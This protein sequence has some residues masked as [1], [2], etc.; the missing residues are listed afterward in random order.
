[1]ARPLRIHLPGARYHVMSRGNGGQRIF[2]D[3]RDYAKFLALLA[4]SLARFSVRCLS[5]CLM[6]THFHLVLEPGER[7]ISGMMQQLNSSYARWFNKRRQ[8]VGHVFQGRFKALVVDTDHYFLRLLRYVAR[9]PVESGAVSRP[10]AWRWSSYRGTAGAEPPPEFLAID[11]VL[12][13]LHPTDATAARQQFI[14]LVASTAEDLELP[15]GL[16]FGSA[17]FEQRV[18]PLLRARRTDQELSY[19]ERY[20]IRPPLAA[21]LEALPDRDAVN[22]RMHEAFFEHA[23][24]LREIG[25]FVGQHPSTIWRRIR[26]RQTDSVD[27]SPPGRR[28]IKNQDLTPRA[29]AHAGPARIKNQDLTPG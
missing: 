26:Q 28:K 3:R 23:Y 5:Y 8:R 4:S 22:R 14:A 10:D 27:P 20:A 24:T 29:T 17:A 12:R 25:D 15:T 18:E 7:P 16:V 13:A 1:M 11:D 19:S 9:N 2:Y 21:L 6:K